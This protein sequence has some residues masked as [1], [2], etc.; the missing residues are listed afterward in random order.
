MDPILAHM[1][2][3]NFMSESFKFRIFKPEKFANFIRIAVLMNQTTRQQN[4]TN[5]MIGLLP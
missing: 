2:K 1:N 4:E 3:V 5:N